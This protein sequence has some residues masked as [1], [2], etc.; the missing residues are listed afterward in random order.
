[1]EEQTGD[2]LPSEGKKCK[3]IPC[4]VWMIFAGLGAGVLVAIIAISCL[5]YL[6]PVGDAFVSKVVQVV[7]YPA[8]VVGTQT[9]SMKDLYE[10]YRA[11][12]TYFSTLETAPDIAPDQ[13]ISM[14]VQTLVRKVAVRDLMQQYGL[15]LDDTKITEMYT[16]MADQVGG[17]EALAGKIFE[18][19]GWSPEEFKMRVVTPLVMAD[20]LTAFIDV[21]EEIQEVRRAEAQTYHDRVTAG[22]DFLTVST[23]ALKAHGMDGNGDY[24]EVTVA[25]LP[26]EWQAAIVGKEAGTMTD[27]VDLSGAFFVVFVKGW[28]PATEAQSGADSVMIQYLLVPHFTLEDA[29][30]E[31][32]DNVWVWKIVGEE[33]ETASDTT[34]EGT[35]DQATDNTA[36]ESTDQTTDQSATTEGSETT[37]Q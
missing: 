20:Q 23:E 8:A 16:S 26:P 35:G 37:T 30:G 28:V 11:M 36:Q 13:V 21:S 27:P 31:Y 34:T 24:G 1:M 2:C 29:V 14:I 32:L 5:V 10:E 9:V 15:T 25:D 3:K 22:E 33:E 6:R 12:Q 18:T 19:F 4:K 17:E 7:P